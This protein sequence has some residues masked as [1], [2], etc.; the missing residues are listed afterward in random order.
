MELNTKYIKDIREKSLGRNG[1][2]LTMEELAYRLDLTPKT[3]CLMENKP[4]FNPT[5]R[6]LHKVSEYFNVSLDNLV[7][8]Q[9]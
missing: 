5:I 9:K 8:K 7:I 3:I 1:K 4:S 6:T 2:P